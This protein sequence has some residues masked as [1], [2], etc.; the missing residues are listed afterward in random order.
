MDKCK[1]ESLKDHY[2]CGKYHSWHSPHYDNYY[3]AQ[4]VEFSCG[5]CGHHVYEDESGRKL[6]AIK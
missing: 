6:N 3:N 1:A 5:R 2:D 4:V